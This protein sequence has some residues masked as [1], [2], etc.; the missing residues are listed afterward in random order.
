MNRRL[1]DTIIRYLSFSEKIDDG[2]DSLGRFSVKQWERTYAW[3]DQ[4]DLEFYLLQKLRDTQDDR[5]LPPAV[6]S[7]LQQ[8]Y[9]NNCARVDEMASQFAI[10]NEKFRESGV[11]YAVVK[12]YSLVPEFC[13]NAALRQ[14]SDL[15]YLIE[16][17]SVPVARQALEQAGFA[18]K[19]YKPAS[20]EWIFC[21]AP[22]SRSTASGGQ[23]GGKAY[24]IELQLSIW[25]PDEH[26]I[27]LADAPFSPTRTV[28]HEWRGMRFPVLYEE[29]A[30]LLQILHVFQHLLSGDVRMRWLYEIA[31]YLRRRSND[32][33]FWQRV[34]RRTEADALLPHFVAIITELA[35]QFFHAP[36]PPI[37]R[38]WKADLRPSVKVWLENYGWRLPFEKVPIYEL[39]IFPTSKL[40]LFLHRQFLQDDK[41]RRNLMR[42]RLLPWSRPVSIVRSIRDKPSALFDSQERHRQFMIHR[43][44]FHTGSGLR[45]LYEIPR[46]WW[47]NRSKPA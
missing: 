35:A 34:E 18:V 43:V 27:H 7:R 45:Y 41:L 46:W 38:T 37:I 28:D 9:S 31:Y 47:L 40:V 6:L 20:G 14:Q 21:K 29:D 32:A 25:R 17:Q 44:I 42:Q 39:G 24:V 30:F 16:E 15:D 12:G 10:V 1:A 19:K 3:L 11:R 36:L 2:S 22:I 4:M 33:S 13:P 5:K 8:S 26:G 23:Y